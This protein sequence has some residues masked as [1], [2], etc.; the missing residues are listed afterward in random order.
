MLPSVLPLTEDAGAPRRTYGVKEQHRNS[1]GWRVS[2]YLWTKSIAAGAFLVPALRSLADP[3]AT[4]SAAP[5]LLA[6]IFLAITSVLLIA[7]LRQ[8]KRFL[9]TLTKPQW[10]SWLTR[11]SYILAAYGG[12][13]TLQLG[14]ARVLP[15]APAALTAL[16]ALMM[17][18]ERPST[19][20]FSSAAKGRDLWQ[21]S[22]VRTPAAAS[23]DDTGAALA[24]PRWLISLLPINAI[25]IV[26][27]VW[28]RHFPTEDARHATKLI[29]AHPVFY[30][31]GRFG[32]GS[33]IPLAL[34]AL[35]RA[36]R[37]S[38]RHR[39]SQSPAARARGAA[40][41]GS[42]FVWPTQ[43]IPNACEAQ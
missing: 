31:L 38:R 39:R 27:E 36:S 20:R 29:L 3:N 41:L 16:T 37:L 9:W 26:G 33:L 12:L 14:A 22:L 15:C 43:Q 18:S 30:A 19:R 10:R 21:S 5:A 6:L 32:L 28:G 4:L 8:P 7:D 13:L 1:W 17:R 25:L 40:A 34:V 23:V 2:A 24:A 42:T 35:V 11:G